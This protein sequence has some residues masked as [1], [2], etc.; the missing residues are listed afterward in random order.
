MTE[1]SAYR[2]L[3]KQR[4]MAMTAHQRSDADRVITNSVRTLI[5][6]HDWR[7]ICL[8]QSLPNLHEVDTM[9]L[10]NDLR[11][12]THYSVTVIEPTA[13][14]VAPDGPFDVIIVPMLGFNSAHTRLGRG[15]GWYDRFL[16]QQPH[17]TTVGLAYACQHIE[18]LA[19]EPHD[20]PI[21]III[22]E[23]ETYLSP[24]HE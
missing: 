17:T 8:Y 23:H 9:A 13:A 11:S 22:T 4:L 24:R 12:D 14:A 6:H 18:H 3:L 16:S 19:R 21:S 2:Q 5:T 10:I 15:G 20:V 7:R 1:K